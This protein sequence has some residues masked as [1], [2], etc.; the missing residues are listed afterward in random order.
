LATTAANTAIT[1]IARRTT[2][3]AITAVARKTKTVSG[4]AHPTITAVTA[5]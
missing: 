2:K 4:T 3:A 1:C 5:I